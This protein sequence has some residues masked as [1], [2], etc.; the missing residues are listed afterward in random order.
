MRHP[1]R[2]LRDY[3]V[4]VASLDRAERDY[5]KAMVVEHN[6]DKLDKI[7]HKVNQQPIANQLGLVQQG[8]ENYKKSIGKLKSTFLVGA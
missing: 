4:A 3:S 6:F 7:Y 8:L 5:E 2:T 1:D